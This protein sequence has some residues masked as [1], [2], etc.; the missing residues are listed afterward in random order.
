MAECW[1]QCMSLLSSFYINTNLLHCWKNATPSK[2]V[3]IGTE[4]NM[5]ILRGCS[6][7]PFSLRFFLIAVIFLILYVEIALSD[8]FV[9]VIGDQMTLRRHICA[10]YVLTLQAVTWCFERWP[11]PCWW[12]SIAVEQLQL[13]EWG[14]PV[15]SWMDILMDCCTCWAQCIGGVSLLQTVV[16]GA[17]PHP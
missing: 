2:T 8:S 7:L 11:V 6:R 17:F 16:C 15:E 13:I 12:V 9:S 1:G 4:Y 10:A 3:F 14:R 5:C